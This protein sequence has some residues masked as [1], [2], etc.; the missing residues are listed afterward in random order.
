MLALKSNAFNLNTINNQDEIKE[1][2]CN[3]WFDIEPEALLKSNPY[4]YKCK[5]YKSP[6][7]ISKG[8]NGIIKETIFFGHHKANKTK[9]GTI[10]INFG[11]PGANAALNLYLIISKGGIPKT[12]LDNFDIIGVDPRGTGGSAYSLEINKCPLNKIWQDKELAKKCDDLNENR[13]Q[14]I[15]TE[16]YIQDMEKLR[17]LLGEDKIHF[18]GI[19]YGGTVGM[20]YA[21]KYKDSIG[22]LV[23]DSPAAVEVLPKYEPKYK[24]YYESLYN[25]T[26]KHIKDR[27]EWFM[28]KALYFKN[29]KGLLENMT[30]PISEKLL[31]RIKDIEVTDENYIFLNNI[32]AYLMAKN[33]PDNMGA[34][35]KNH[36]IY[37]NNFEGY[38]DKKTINMVW[39][40]RPSLNWEMDESGEEFT[41]KTENNIIF[42]LFA[43]TDL[44]EREIRIM[45]KRCKQYYKKVKAGKI[46]EETRLGISLKSKVTKYY[47]A[48]ST[49]LSEKVVKADRKKMQQ[50]AL[51][52]STIDKSKLENLDALLIVADSD[53]HVYDDMTNENLF[54]LENSIKIIVKNHYNHGLLFTK[55]AIHNNT[56]PQIINLD[57]VNQYDAINQHVANYIMNYGNPNPTNT[58]LSKDFINYVYAQNYN[59]LQYNLIATELDRRFK[60]MTDMMDFIKTREKKK[61]RQRK[62]EEATKGE[63]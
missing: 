28:K 37:R 36:L 22:A 42:D 18:I 54:E 46:I 44:N 41:K 8:I 5:T 12:I 31:Y 58:Q 16:H 62:R 3:H 4:N 13:L 49:L 10:F 6:R 45:L 33:L 26:T 52:G 7:F 25:L 60:R 38:T 47:E 63:K 20:R 55:Q 1:V 43:N 14:Y 11:G 34:Y 51:I 57:S 29:N 50:E 27:T 56:D 30:Y 32:N 53:S 24:D 61:E 9:R 15:S 23:L 19:S 40:S 48:D 59:E 35:R 2:D 21:A 39:G 17:Q